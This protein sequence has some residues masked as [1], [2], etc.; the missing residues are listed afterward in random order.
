VPHWGDTGRFRREL[1]P[2]LVHP[3]LDAGR[4]TLR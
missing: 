4:T 3:T 2:T 1:L